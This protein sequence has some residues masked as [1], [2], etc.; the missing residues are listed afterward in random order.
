LRP[1]VIAEAATIGIFVAYD[2]SIFDRLPFSSGTAGFWWAA[3]RVAAVALAGLVI[4]A[5]LGQFDTPVQL[6]RVT[7][8]RNSAAPLSGYLIN[9]GPDGVDVGLKGKITSLPSG[10]YSTVQISAARSS[11]APSKSIV[12]RLLELL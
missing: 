12:E 11:P 5:L 4:A 1:S 8:D 9:E 10:S 2:M 7:V 6:E 3:R